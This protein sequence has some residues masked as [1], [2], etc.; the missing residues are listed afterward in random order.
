MARA[1]SAGEGDVVIRAP[2]KRDVAV[3]L[4]LLVVMW[5]VA[6][7]LV[8]RPMLPGVWLVGQ[9]L[10]AELRGELPLHALVS[11]ARVLCAIVLATVVGVP[12]GVLLAQNRTADRM[13]SPLLYLLYPVPK[14]VFV[15]L[16]LLWFGVG[17]VPKVLLIVLVLVNQIVVL[18]RDSV[19]QL[20]LELIN[21]VRSLGAAGV[22][23]FRFVYL[24][25]AV[26]ATLSALRQCIGTSFAVLYLA[27][28]IA[29]QYGLG[30]YIYLNGSVLFNY[31]AMYAGIV[32]MGGLG[33]M[34]FVVVDR[35]AQRR[36]R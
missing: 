29:T 9:T 1:V 13:F 6:S 28:M 21:S 16:I 17:N 12:L 32:V 26:P 34:L 27:E 7:W 4:V 10:L 18:V 15:P 33:L 5:Q 2:R 8:A 36:R 19:K 11:L 25:A 31:P 30:Y 20:P 14:V 24:P 3:T 23:L 22:G 35:L